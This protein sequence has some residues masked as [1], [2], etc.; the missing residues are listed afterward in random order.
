VPVPAWFAALVL[1]DAL[2]AASSDSLNVCGGGSET[3]AEET[4][5]VATGDTSSL[6][7]IGAKFTP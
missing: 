7:T 2:E 3:C 4:V 6:S 1:E 5:R